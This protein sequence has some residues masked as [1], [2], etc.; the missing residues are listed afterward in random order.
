MPIDMTN[1]KQIMHGGKEV[2]KI[3]DSNGGILWQKQT[4]QPITI[5]I[6]GTGNATNLFVRITYTDTTSSDIYSADIISVDKS[7]ISSLEIHYNSRTTK[8]LGVV[9]LNGSRVSYSTNATDRTY[10]IDLSNVNSS[11]DIDL[12]YTTSYPTVAWIITDNTTVNGTPLVFYNN[13]SGTTYSAYVFYTYNG[14][15]YSSSTISGRTISGSDT[16]TFTLSRTSTAAGSSNPTVFTRGLT[17]TTPT[18]NNLRQTK[19]IT[20]PSTYKYIVANGRSRIADGSYYYS[21]L[22]VVGK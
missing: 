2:V 9:L 4:S 19:S 8:G 3:E 21:S 20:S 17:T 10:T 7:Q 1:V 5:A 18:S 12:D 22:Y 11:V 15:N 13:N 6:T 16:L 14:T